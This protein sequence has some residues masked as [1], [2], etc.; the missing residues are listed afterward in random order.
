[1]K[2]DLTSPNPNMWDVIAYR[3]KYCEHPHVGDKWCIYPSYDYTHCIVDSL[4]N[5]THSLCTLEF[6]VRRESYY[7]LLHVL[8]LYK[9]S[10]WEFS[11]LNIQYNVLSKRKLLQLVKQNHVRGWDDCRL[12]TINGLRRRGFTPTALNG[13]CDALGVSRNKNSTSP[14]RLEHHVRE[15]LNP[16]ATRAMV[17]LDPLKVTLT[18]LTSDHS[19]A[20]PN[21][22]VDEKMGSR[23]ETLCKTVFIERTDFKEHDVKKYFGLAPGKMVRLRYAFN[24]RCDSVVKND[25]GEVVELLCTALPDD[26]TKVKGFVHWVGASTSVPVEVR[27]YNRLFTVPE[28]VEMGDEWLNYINPDSEIVYRGVASNTIADVKELE[29]LQFERVGYFVCDKDSTADL[30]VFNRI[31]ALK[32][33]K[34]AKTLKK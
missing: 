9:P 24:I 33:S 4:E 3:I 22:P 5:I 6:E 2:M 18:N 26:T 30:K 19:I 20:V 29:R 12:L 28:P 27:V 16:I 17:V 15:E 1:M 7:W 10:V 31:C 23:T 11:R 34:D 13:F 21:N 32:A 8:D 14:E 25:A